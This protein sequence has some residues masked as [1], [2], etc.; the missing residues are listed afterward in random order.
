M[1]GSSECAEKLFAR[2]GSRC[3]EVSTYQA[4][5]DTPFDHYPDMTCREV[6]F[7]AEKEKVVHLDDLILRRSLM[8][9]L[10][11][12]NR[13]LIDELAD[14]LAEVLGW[15]DTQKKTEIERTLDI[16]QDIHGVGI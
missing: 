4:G 12:L 2:Y 3:R 9:Y 8:A 13:L 11:H 5:D 10:G 1:K 16:L 15:S 7:L 6:A 14:I